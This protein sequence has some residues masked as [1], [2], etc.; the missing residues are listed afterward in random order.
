MPNY[1]KLFTKRKDGRYRTTYTD[2]NGKLKYLYDRDP[3]ALWNKLQEA[4][5][6]RQVTFRDA[7]EAW[8]REYRE[9]CN[10]RTWTNYKPH[11]ESIVDKFADSAI[12]LHSSKAYALLTPMEGAAGSVNRDHN[13]E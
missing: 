10:V 6:P 11:Y 7:A 9:S 4:Q 8:E 2:E 13:E 3:E 12:L 1:N 5:K